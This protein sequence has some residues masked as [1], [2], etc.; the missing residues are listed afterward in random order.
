MKAI[1]G[2]FSDPES[3]QRAMAGLRSNGPGWGIAAREVCVM[4]SEPFEEYDLGWR[5]QKTPMPWLAA[6][7]GAIGGTFGYALA[8]FTQRSYPLTTGNMP[9]VALWPSS[10]IVYELTMLGAIVTT[11]ITLLISARIPNWRSKVYDAAI[12]EGKILVGVL[13]PP[14]KTHSQLEQLLRQAGAGVVKNYEPSR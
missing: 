8:S 3:A 13:N 4:S 10:I 14:E 6:F 11:L 1:Y 2:L 7:G 5:E 12:S 9:I